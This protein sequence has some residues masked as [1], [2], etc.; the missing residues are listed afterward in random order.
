M[1]NDREST[2]SVSDRARLRAESL[3]DEQTIER[4]W[5]GR[6]R[7]RDATAERLTAAAHRLGIAR[8]NDARRR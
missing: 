2:L 8:P 3:C 7:V 5:A 1:L 4:W 6:H